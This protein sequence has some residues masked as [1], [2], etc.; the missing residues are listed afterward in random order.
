[1]PVETETETIVRPETPQTD[2]GTEELQRTLTR[3]LP[4]Y[5]VLLHNDDHNAMEHVVY[6]LLL[7]VQSLTPEDA[8]SIML[9]AHTE[10]VALVIVTP[11]ER[12][13]FYRE[14]LEQF[15]LTSTIEPDD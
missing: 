5:R 1:M 13:E 11:K 12:A 3:L 9:E 10:G 15:G 4:P 7:T 6:A 8:V 14:K 2:V